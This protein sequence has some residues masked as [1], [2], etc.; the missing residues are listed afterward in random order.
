MKRGSKSPVYGLIVA[1]LI[2]SISFIFAGKALTATTEET[3]K[4]GLIGPMDRPNTVDQ[5]HMDEIYEDMINKTGGLSIGG[6]KY[7]IAYKRF[8]SY[9]IEP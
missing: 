8:R 5:I 4:I 6:Q 9:R 2:L 7:K 3:L 1:V